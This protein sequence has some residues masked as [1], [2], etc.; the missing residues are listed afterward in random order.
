MPP[1][2]L[3]AA[4]NAW[5]A[6]DG[7]SRSRQL[8]QEI[9]Q[10]SDGFRSRHPWMVRH[11]NSIG[12]GIFVF[13]CVAVVASAVAYAQGLLPAWL[14]IVLSAIWMSLLHELE[15]DLIHTL[16]FRKNTFMYN[17]MMAGVWLF[18]P[19]T[20][21]PWVRRDMHINHHKNAGTEADFE[22]RMITNGEPW[23]FKRLLMTGD[24][25]LAIYLRP[26]Q[27][28]RMMTAYIFARFPGATVAVR[29]RESLRNTLGMFPLQ[30]LHY[31]LWH[32]FVLWHV[33]AFVAAQSGHAIV[34]T[35]FWSQLIS[36]VD[37]LAV[38]WLLPNVLRVF[39]LH[40]VSSNMHYYGDIDAGNVIQQTQVWS[41]WWL[42][43]LQ[44]F[45]FNFG[46]T[47]GIHHFVVRDPF[48]LRQMIAKEVYP[49]LHRHGVRFNDFSAM[50]RANRWHAQ[51]RKGH[52]V[53]PEPV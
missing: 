47:H 2:A 20:V 15:H 19:S 40:F 4:V 33:T 43:P 5:T 24:H 29:A 7:I 37:F 41:A 52:A 39:C 36:A 48:Y 34:P 49:I 46:A 26:V 12:L 9:M 45:C 13:A 42:W 8:Q 44:L 21:S 50:C 25:M 10:I 16:Y 28:H 30:V 14:T 11:Q 18:R 3:A 1:V 22:E 27:L 32:G 17:L 53:C 31:V 35:L 51:E 38:V 6:A 23:G